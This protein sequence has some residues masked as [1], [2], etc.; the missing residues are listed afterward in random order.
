[1][2]RKIKINNQEIDY[3]IKKSKRAK[4]L[5]IAVYCDATV[6]VTLPFLA[7]E[8]IVEK[9]L[10]EKSGWL[11]KKISYFKKYKNINIPVLTKNDYLK[12]KNKALIIARNIIKKYNQECKFKFNKITIKNQKTRWGSCSRKGN[13]NINYKIIYLPEKIAEYIVVHEICHLIEFNHSR[14]FWNLVAEIF[15][16]YLDIRR[17]LKK[18][19]L[20]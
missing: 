9:F 18:K 20:F 19:G 12:N 7:S 10:K 17:E 5:R 14:K 8:K 16:D 1:M 2:Q 11:I 15:P 13:I 6:V 4:R 3:K